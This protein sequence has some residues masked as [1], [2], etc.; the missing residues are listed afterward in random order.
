MGG[1][2]KIW[3]SL[4]GRPVLEWTLTRFKDAGVTSG[5]V[6]AQAGDHGRIVTL[7]ESLGLAQF[8]VTTGGA[9]RYLSVE[10]GLQ[11]LSGVDGRDIILVHD[12]ARCLVSSA[13]IQQVA[14]AARESGAALPVLEVVD[15]VKTVSPEGFVTAT[16]PRHTLGLAQTPQG[17]QKALIDAAY[18]DW[19]VGR[20]PTDDAEV[21]ERAGQLVRTVAGERQNLKLTRPEDIPWFEAALKGWNA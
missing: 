15:T 2:S 17:F 18:R 13:L 8:A 4:S 10:A 16:V 14:A 20:V 1:A 6:V 9:E 19:P 7:F 12:A 5:V 11:A 3:L 21:A